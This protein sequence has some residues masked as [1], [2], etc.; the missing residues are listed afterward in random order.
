MNRQNRAPKSYTVTSL[1]H[2]DAMLSFAYAP[3]SMPYWAPVGHD[4][5]GH[6]SGARGHLR[7]RAICGKTVSPAPCALRGLLQ[8]N[9]A[10]IEFVLG[11]FRGWIDSER[12]SPSGALRPRGASTVWYARGHPSRCSSPRT[13]SGCTMAGTPP[14]THTWGGAESYMQ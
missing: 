6:G 1:C 2:C 8:S 7:A 9:T 14:V 4:T 10:N 13:T 5:G 3:L 12:G 11:F